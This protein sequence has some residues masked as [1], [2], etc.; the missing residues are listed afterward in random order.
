VRVVQLVGDGQV[1]TRFIWSRSVT[2]ARYEGR[3]A[4]CL[5]VGRGRRTQLGLG[6]LPS[7]RRP[8]RGHLAALGE[9]RARDAQAVG[10]QLI[11]ASEVGGHDALDSGSRQDRQVN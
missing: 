4:V 1:P 2:A 5:L 9:A 10:D 11:R 6:V 3:E 8:E 7:G